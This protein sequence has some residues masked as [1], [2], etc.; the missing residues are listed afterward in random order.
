LKGLSEQDKIYN[1][2]ISELYKSFNKK[3][4]EITA[5][6][7]PK[8]LLGPIDSRIIK[9]FSYNRNMFRLYSKETQNLGRQ[10]EKRI[11]YGL[12]E[13]NKKE[14]NIEVIWN[15]EKKE[16]GKPYDIIIKKND[17]VVQYIEVKT[18]HTDEKKF[19]ISKNEYE[20]AMKQ[21]EKYKLYLI[22]NAGAG[23]DTYY[24]EIENFYEKYNN[25]SFEVKSRELI[26]NG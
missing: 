7:T 20:F 5:F 4:K 25:L 24:E 18:T 1:N 9:N 17:K 10:G 11:F 3:I 22:I 6:L 26:Y 14:K 23:V 13:I 12:R 2:E 21:R 19:W 8:Q 15:N 16:S